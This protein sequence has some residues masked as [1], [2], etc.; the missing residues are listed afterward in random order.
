MKNITTN[1]SSIVI[2]CLLGF[3]AYQH[4]FAN[5]DYKKEYEKM[6]QEK[7]QAYKKEI[8]RLVEINDSIFLVN[9]KL[10]IDIGTIDDRINEKNAQLANLRRKYAE[11]VSKLDSMSNDELSTIFTNTFK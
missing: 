2:L 10:M 3:I 5:T 6:L 9:E 4:F 1:L 8:E 7:E 11:Q